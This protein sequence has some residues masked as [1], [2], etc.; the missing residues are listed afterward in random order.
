MHDQLA[1]KSLPFPVY[2]GTT[3]ALA[4]LTGVITYS[5]AYDTTLGSYV[6]YNGAAWVSFATGTVA[7]A[8]TT[9]GGKVKVST[10]D[11]GNT[12]TA[13]NSTDAKYAALAGTGTPSGSNKFVTADTLA[14]NITAF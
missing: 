5:I 7:D 3:A 8:T 4:A 6:Y 12:P 14:A 2:S 10:A 13:L 11:A 9:V 1:D